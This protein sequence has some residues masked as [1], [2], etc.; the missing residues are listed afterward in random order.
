M[1]HA[2]YIRD[3]ASSRIVGNSKR[4]VSEVRTNTHVVGEEDTV[5]VVEPV[6]EDP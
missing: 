4:G 2:L 6:R 3:A 1:H 5:L